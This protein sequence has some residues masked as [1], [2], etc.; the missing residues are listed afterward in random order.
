[1]IGP[2]AGLS[3][4]KLVTGGVIIA[5][6]LTTGT[7]FYLHYRNVVSQRDAALQSVGKL[8]VAL[9]V[10]EQTVNAQRDAIE[11]W[12]GQFDKIEARLQELSAATAEA[13]KYAKEVNDVLSKHDLR[14]LSLAKPGLIER[15]INRGS[16]DVNR[17]LESISAG[18]SPDDN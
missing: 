3:T 4:A 7:L 18:G 8:E 10:Q 1:M 17:M 11:Q 15:R 16:A 5:T 12:K 13:N 2:L 9:Q 6:L 14:K